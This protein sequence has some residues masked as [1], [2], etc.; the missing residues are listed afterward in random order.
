MLY[1][2]N[3]G[4]TGNSFS[5]TAKRQMTSV[6][7]HFCQTLIIRS[8]RRQYRSGKS[9]Q[10]PS[11]ILAPISLW[12]TFFSNSTWT[13]FSIKKTTLSAFLPSLMA[14]RKDSSL[15]NVEVLTCFFY[16]LNN[17]IMH[18]KKSVET[19]MYKKQQ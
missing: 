8:P 18:F 14:W 15:Q 4:R 1:L 3:V 19:Q 17:T 2:C 16:G 13:S 6:F 11:F 5:R 9:I 7:F 10:E 12:I